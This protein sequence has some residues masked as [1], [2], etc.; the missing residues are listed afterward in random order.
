VELV[1]GIG[2]NNALNP[3]L[4]ECTQGSQIACR[5][6]GFT[7]RIAELMGISDLLVTKPGPTTIFEAIYRNLFMVIDAT[8]PVIRWEEMNIAFVKENGLGVVIKDLDDLPQIVSKIILDTVYRDEMKQRSSALKKYVF[9][10][11]I[12][13]FLTESLWI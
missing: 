11:E 6:V 13:R 7:S 8:R 2:R 1:I 12:Q 4:A 5:I 10:D 9:R 3:H